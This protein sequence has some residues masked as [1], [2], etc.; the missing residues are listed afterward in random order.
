M[1]RASCLATGACRF[2]H[3]NTSICPKTL[4]SFS[5]FNRT[6]DFYL[7]FSGKVV[8][9]Y[10]DIYF[11]ILSVW[12]KGGR[13]V[14]A[15]YLE[16]FYDLTDENKEK[17]NTFIEILSRKEKNNIGKGE[18]NKTGLKQDRGQDRRCLSAASAD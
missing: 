12:D 7:T 13:I 18:A 8:L 3:D 9:S 5:K 15:K 11:Y 2:F 17:V 10:Q 14:E 1:R 16:M 4:S 6:V